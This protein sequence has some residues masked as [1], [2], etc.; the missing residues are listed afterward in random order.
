MSGIELVSQTQNDT[1]YCLFLSSPHPSLPFIYF[2]VAPH[3]FIFPAILLV[4]EVIQHLS[5][6]LVRYI[7]NR[8]RHNLNLFIKGIV[9]GMNA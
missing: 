5:P 3:P 7:E 6:P 9:M 1:Q 4:L 8:R 2:Q